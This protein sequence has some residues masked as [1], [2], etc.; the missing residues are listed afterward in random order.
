LHASFAGWVMHDPKTNKTGVIRQQ[1]AIF[2]QLLV[3]PP[4]RLPAQKK[5]VSFAF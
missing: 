4:Q 1:A 3:R 5:V 2:L